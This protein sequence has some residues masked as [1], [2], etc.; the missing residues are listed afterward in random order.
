MKGRDP[1][2]T[3]VVATHKKYMMPKD[4]LYL[5]LEVGVDF[6]GKKTNY[7]GDNTGTNISKKNDGFS[8]L[9]GLYWAFK[10][11]RAGYKGLVHYRRYFTVS[12]CR[13]GNSKK[14]LEKVL[15][16]KQ[17][18]KILIN[19]DVVLPRKRN[20]VIENL[21]DHYIHTMH[22]EPLDLTGE[23]IKEKYPKYYNEF[24]K[25]HERK[26]AHMFNMMIMRDGIFDEYCNWLFDILFE[27]EKRVKKAGLKYDE[28]H[29]RFY[30]RISELLLDVYIRTNGIDYT[31]LPVISIEPVNWIK[32]GGSFLRAKFLGKKYKESF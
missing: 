22:K 7:Q 12:R 15:T 13:F 9:T 17:A 4:E 8:E 5:P 32:K 31:E 20:Y 2:I 18:K 16:E 23:I 14:R 27:L 6:H 28:F 21:Y 11:L 1:E 29:A 25:L 24:L 30:G 19:C 10:N 26:T 3:V